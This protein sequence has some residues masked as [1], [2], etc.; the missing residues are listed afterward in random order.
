M[1]WNVMSP[2]DSR[3]ASTRG[4]EQLSLFTLAY[5]VP[6]LEWSEPPDL[7]SVLLALALILIPWS[8]IGWLIATLV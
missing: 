8:L 4:Y 1:S 3:L 6:R 2:L 7:S 5:N